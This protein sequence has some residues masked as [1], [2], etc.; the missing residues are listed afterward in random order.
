MQALTLN[1]RYQKNVHALYQ[2]LRAPCTMLLESAEVR[3]KSGK[4]SIIGLNCAVKIVVRGRT[5]FLYPR[6]G[7]GRAVCEALKEHF[8]F[9]KTPD[10][11]LSTSFPEPPAGLDETARLKAPGPLDVLREIRLMFRDFK[12]L[13]LAGLISFDFIRTFEHFEPLPDEDDTPDLCFYLYDLNVVVNHIDQTLSINL[14]AF[15]DES[16]TTLGMR[17]LQI[18]SLIDSR[19]FAMELP[20]VKLTGRPDFKADLDDQQFGAMV[21]SL[22]EH[23]CC[24]DI[25][26]VVPSRT[27]RIPCRDS[28]LA[29]SYLKSDNPSPYAFFFDDEDFVLFGTSPEFALRFDAASRVTAISPIAG[30]RARGVME[31]GS[32]DRDLD[33]RL[34]L[35][36]RT[37][38]KEIAEHLMLVDLA[39]NDLARIAEPGTRHVSN[40]LHVDRYQSVMH[41]VSDVT[42]VLRSDLDALHAYLAAMNMGTLSGAPKIKAHELIYRYEGRKRGFYGGVAAILSADGSFDSCIVIRSAL[43]KNDMAQVQAGCGV[44]Y[45]SDPQAEAEETLNKARSVLLAVA[46]SEAARS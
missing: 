6:S 14:F 26:Q 18:K 24:G 1:A 46:K 5:V 38:K 28:F 19:D 44:V 9:T 27:F 3:D 39:R 12:P 30:T 8:T 31:D 32:L 22:K 21:N 35:E 33:E 34:E 4:Q 2:I 42:A 45:D 11:A 25:F 13:T 15:D 37:D 41:L 40:L 16:Y 23:I 10:G 17:A 7:S 20:E 36:L 29:Y 43:V